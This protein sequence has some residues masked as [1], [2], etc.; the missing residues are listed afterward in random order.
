[1]TSPTVRADFL[2][3]VGGGEAQLAHGVDDAALD[4]LQP[5]AERRQSAIENNVH[6]I[7]EVRLFGECAQGLLLNTLEIQFL[8]V[9]SLF[10]NC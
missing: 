6:R 7:V 1:M 4:R 9:H 5:V 10:S 3:L 8:I 2:V